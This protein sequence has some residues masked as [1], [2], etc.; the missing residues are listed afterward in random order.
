MSVAASEVGNEALRYPITRRGAGHVLMN[1]VRFPLSVFAGVDLS[2]VRTVE[3]R[4]T[5]TFAGVI[6]VSDVAFAA[7]AS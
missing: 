5:R 6:D 3:F 2:D 7:Q 4:F 1:Q